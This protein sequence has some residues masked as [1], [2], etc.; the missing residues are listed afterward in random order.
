MGTSLLLYVPLQTPSRKLMDA[1]LSLMQE[2]EEGG[3]EW[4]SFGKITFLSEG[5]GLSGRKVKYTRGKKRERKRKARS[6]PFSEGF[7]RVR[8]KN[9]FSIQEKTR[10]KKRKLY[11]EKSKEKKKKVSRWKSQDGG[12][13]GR[14]GW[15][16]GSGEGG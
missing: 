11:L 14:K 2:E 1:L 15:K 3:Q 9:L 7:S 6:I 8:K 5:K 16:K 4:Y 10:E 12:W 13:P